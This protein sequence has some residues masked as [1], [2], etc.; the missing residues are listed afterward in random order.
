MWK[1]ILLLSALVGMLSAQSTPGLAH[2]RL[3][4][5]QLQLIYNLAKDLPVGTEV[6]VALIEGETTEYLG[7]RRKEKGVTSVDNHDRTFAIGS[8]SK[9][10]TGVLLADAV[11]NGKVSVTDTVNAAYDFSFA[12]GQAF[13]YGELASHEAGLPKIPTNLPDMTEED[14]D[15]YATYT[16][17]LLAD[18]LR[19]TMQL[20]KGT[21]VY[22]NLGFGLLAYT[23][24]HRLDST[25][26]AQALDQRVFGPLGMKHASVGPDSNRAKLVVGRNDN[27]TPATY[28]TFTEAMVGAGGI[29]ASPEDLV[30]FL[31]AQ[32][33]T[34]QA[35]LQ[36][37]R[38]PLVQLSERQAVG[39]GWQIIR[40]EPEVTVHWHNGAVG[41]YSSFVAVDTAGRRG[42][43]VL[44]S[45]LL[46][47]GEAD[48]T[49]MQLLRGLKAE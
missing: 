17:A 28:W 26:Y 39:M 29:V 12:S 41:G 10:F 43:V 45:T 25:T 36:L 5:A 38:E 49:A 44:V 22:S 4:S 47:G 23:L 15:P 1:L 48:R 7:A 18:Y 13:T 42:V 2:E 32:F 21:N 19:D 33:D 34:T 20:D 46:R 16:P 35:A 27:G 8:I 14:L 9:V 11:L 6:G 3:D 24:T 40:P 37:A 31:R 30:R